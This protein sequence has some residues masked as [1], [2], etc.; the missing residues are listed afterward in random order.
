MSLNVNLELV[1][2]G[3]LVEIEAPV[4][5]AVFRGA[6]VCLDDGARC[7][8]RLVVGHVAPCVDIG[9]RVQVR[10]FTTDSA[11]SPYLTFDD[12]EPIYGI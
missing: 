11:A 5:G 8:C 3:R 4:D 1:F 12:M 2:E 10:R 9:A 6:V 7:P